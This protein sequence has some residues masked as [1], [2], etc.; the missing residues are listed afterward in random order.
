M[1]HFSGVF[2]VFGGGTRCALVA[3]VFC[4]TGCR[5]TYRTEISVKHLHRTLSHIALLGTLLSAAACATDSHAPFV[6]GDETAAAEGTDVVR[7]PVANDDIAD[8]NE[9]A[10]DAGSTWAR[11]SATS[12]PSALVDEEADLDD[13]GNPSIDQFDETQDIPANLFVYM[14]AAPVEFDE[15]SVEITGVDINTTIDEDHWLPIMTDPLTVDLLALETDA[16]TLGSAAL[17]PGSYAQLRLFID[18]P[19]VLSGTEDMPVFMPLVVNE[20]IELDVEFD[21]EEGLA[22]SIVLDFDALA[23]IRVDG[24]GA[25]LNPVIRI[26]S[27]TATGDDPAPTSADGGAAIV[28]PSEKSTEGVDGGASAFDAG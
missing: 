11:L 1:G 27:L 13:D 16:V 2:R 7:D 9:A 26:D 23:S 10:A 21:I 12:M 24:N 17:Q 19:K 3:V 18:N 4:G 8:V 6:Q 20:G 14:K 5:D 15:V 25:H 22:Y 28:E